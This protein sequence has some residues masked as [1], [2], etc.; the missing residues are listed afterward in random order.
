[1]EDL[2]LHIL[3]IIDNAMAA[4]AS[5][6]GVRILLES[7]NDLLTVEITDNGRG[8]DPETAAKALDPFYSSKPGKRIG[9]GIPLLAQASREA[10]GRLL[11]FSEPSIGTRIVASFR[12]SHPDRKPLGDVE[13]TMYILQK[14]H[15]EI[16]FSFEYVKK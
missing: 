4:G 1:M 10:E 7:E 9:L 12:L 16:R 5:E 6:I 15:P 14:T 13:E 3:D 11:L 2:S 8:M